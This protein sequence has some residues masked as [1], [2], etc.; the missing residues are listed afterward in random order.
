MPLTASLLIAIPVAL[1][2]LFLFWY[3]GW[4]KPMTQIP[5]GRDEAASRDLSPRLMN[6]RIP[7]LQMLIP[8]N[9][10]MQKRYK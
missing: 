9:I 1:Y 6:L 4:G 8:K 7:A 3:G 2:L 5:A 10:Q